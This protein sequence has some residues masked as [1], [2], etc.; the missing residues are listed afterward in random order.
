MTF[1]ESCKWYK[2]TND[3]HITIWT[4]TFS[5]N[6]DK[7]TSVLKPNSL[8]LILEIRALTSIKFLMNGKIFHTAL[9]P[10]EINTFVK[11]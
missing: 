10:E 1:F 9:F 6:P 8:I 4:G 7:I 5:H 3:K 2:Y 11:I